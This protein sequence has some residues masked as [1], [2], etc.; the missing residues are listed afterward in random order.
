LI[1]AAKVPGEESYGS[2]WKIF[3]LDEAGFF[4]NTFSGQANAFII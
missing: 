1:V 2:S 4:A 3:R